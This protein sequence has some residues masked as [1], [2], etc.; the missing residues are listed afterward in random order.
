MAGGPVLTVMIGSHDAHP[1][2]GAIHQN[3]PYRCEAAGE[4]EMKF[5]VPEPQDSHAALPASDLRICRTCSRQVVARWQ[6][7]GPLAALA[8][9]DYQ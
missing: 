6:R 8:R 3:R 2:R 9:I 4:N 7:T 1:A 5:S